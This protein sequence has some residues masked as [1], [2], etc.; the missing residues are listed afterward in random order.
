MQPDIPALERVS[1]RRH[2]IVVSNMATS[3]MYAN[4]PFEVSAN[5]A[6]D[7]FVKYLN[8]PKPPTRGTLA[9]GGAIKKIAFHTTRPA[10]DDSRHA[11]ER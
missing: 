10:L 3:R 1:G 9:R 4:A 5:A 6:A 8:D 2:L 11:N 7:W